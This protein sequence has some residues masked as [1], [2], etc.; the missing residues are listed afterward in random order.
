MAS[1]PFESPETADA[2]VMIENLKAEVT[3]LSNQIQA[4]L[5]ERAGNLKETVGQATEDVEGV[6]RNNPLMSVGIAAGAGLLLGLMMRRGGAQRFEQP[7]KE[8][9][10]LVTTLEEAI[11]SSKARFAEMAERQ[12]E[13]ALLERLT[14]AVS[15]L[16]DTSK[17][18]A[19]SVAEKA[20][21]NVAAVGEKTARSISDRL[22]G[23]G[24]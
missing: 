12:G 19:S 21:R 8:L 23:N 13:S 3:R 16:L 2:A 18:T 22:T 14:S 11:E 1:E 20:A 7:R 4:I 9:Q 6:I 5:E 24:R 17:A 10:Q 15:S